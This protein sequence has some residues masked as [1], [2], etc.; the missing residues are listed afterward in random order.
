MKRQEYLQQGDVL[1]F[2][3]SEIPKSAKRLQ[4]AV[5]QEGEHTGHA[6]R[7]LFR[8]G[9]K[10]GG[11]FQLPD[12]QKK[13]LLAEEPVSLTHEEHE[14]FEIPV[15]KREVRIVQEYDHFAEEA[16]NVAD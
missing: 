9:E 6:H 14:A 8:H 4:S 5:L 12:S 16:R 3:I 10:S 11:V 7:C 13:F 2:E 15:S 1:L